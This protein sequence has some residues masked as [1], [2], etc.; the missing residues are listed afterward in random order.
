MGVERGEERSVVGVLE[1]RHSPTCRTAWARILTE[2]E[3]PITRISITK[4]GASAVSR[5]LRPGWFDRRSATPAGS[6]YSPMVYVGDTG[7]VLAGV[8]GGAGGPGL[9][10]D[11]NPSAGWVIPAEQ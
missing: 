11:R 2:G 6:Y 5:D 7:R 8:R 9:A 4:A 3:S 1:V 10:G